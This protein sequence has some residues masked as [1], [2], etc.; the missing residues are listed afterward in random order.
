MTGTVLAVAIT[1]ISSTGVSPALETSRAAVAPAA[2][3][4]D[5]PGDA[6]T[7]RIVP[8]RFATDPSRAWRS[9]PSARA[10]SA[11]ARRFSLT[12]RIIAVGAGL[13]V[14]FLVGGTIGGKLTESDNPDDDTSVLKGIMI[15]APIGGAV[16]AILGWRL[17]K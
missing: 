15:G 13:T 17:T 11:P 16:G 14:G 7:S 5:F 3:T 1:M 9:Q 12:E 10:Q 4:F 8:R 2:F 6:G